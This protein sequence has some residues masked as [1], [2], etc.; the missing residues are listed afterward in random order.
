M[1]GAPG[2]A[3]SG[4]TPCT[5]LLEFACSAHTPARAAHA[6]ARTRALRHRVPQKVRRKEGAPFERRR[7]SLPDLGP[8]TKFP[9]LCTHEFDGRLREEGSLSW[10]SESCPVS[11]SARHRALASGG[12][13]QPN[14]RDCPRIDGEG[15][16][17]SVLDRQCRKDSESGLSAA[18]VF[19]TAVGADRLVTICSHSAVW[20]AKTPRSTRWLGRGGGSCLGRR[21]DRPRSRRSSW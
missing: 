19:Q 5:T 8:H 9:A 17:E 16:L 10:V 1:D 11:G 14:V 20:G 15:R 6:R 13:R 4:S 21:R 7:P 12:L 18:P 2:T 3:S